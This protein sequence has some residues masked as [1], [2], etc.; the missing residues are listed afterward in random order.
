MKK[1]L[2]YFLQEVSK[3]KTKKTKNTKIN[4][5]GTLVEALISVAIISFVIVSILSGFSQQQADTSRNTDKN[6]AVMLAEMRMEELLKFPS[7]QLKKETFVDYIVLKPNG[8]K[9]YGEK[10]TIPNELRQFKR[11]AIISEVPDK[12]VDPLSQMVQITVT[13]SYGAMREK[14]GSSTLM[15]PYSVQLSSRRSLK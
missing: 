3:L 14:I 7:T 6:M 5:G 2:L 11:E 1:Q 12:T 10:D 8:F 9:V 15:Y 13:V 4:K